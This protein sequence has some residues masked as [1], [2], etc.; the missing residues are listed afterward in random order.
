MNERGRVTGEA[1][2]IGCYEIPGSGRRPDGTDLEVEFILGRFDHGTA[3][4]I[5]DDGRS[6]VV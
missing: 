3:S 1:R 5:R 6:Q 2:I 4:V